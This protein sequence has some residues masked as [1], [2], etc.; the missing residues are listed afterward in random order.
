MSVHVQLNLMLSIEV[1]PNSD[2]YFSL[3][4]FIASSSSAD[5]YSYHNDILNNTHYEIVFVKKMYCIKLI[6]IF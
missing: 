3:D 4:N 5:T 2:K 6:I 1:N